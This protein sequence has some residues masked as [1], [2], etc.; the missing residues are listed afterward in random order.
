M[1]W[2]LKR[3]AGAV[4]EQ[5]QN[6]HVWTYHSNMLSYLSEGMMLG[7]NHAIEA[8]RWHFLFQTPSK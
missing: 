6:C 4:S 5:E 7:I 8:S 2:S 3:H 1:L